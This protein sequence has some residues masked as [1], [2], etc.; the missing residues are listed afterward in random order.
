M[1][2]PP[3]PTRQYTSIFKLVM[4]LHSSPMRTES[5]PSL[6]CVFLRGQQ[7]G[8]LRKMNSLQLIKLIKLYLY[9]KG[10]EI[11]SSLRVTISYFSLF[12][13]LDNILLVSSKTLFRISANIILMFCFRW[14]RLVSQS[15]RHWS[16]WST[17]RPISDWGKLRVAAEQKT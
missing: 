2:F 4:T 16:P 7:Q 11:T 1:S 3:S 12:V 9:R 14:N 17:I 10:T 6:R 5:L 8:C 13:K 15:M